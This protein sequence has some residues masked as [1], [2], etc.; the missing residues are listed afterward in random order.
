MTL[1]KQA[2]I[3]FPALHIPSHLLSCKRDKGMKIAIETLLAS[4]LLQPLAAFPVSHKLVTTET[5]PLVK[6]DLVL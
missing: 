3:E 5:I 2:Q 6:S 4:L 1:T